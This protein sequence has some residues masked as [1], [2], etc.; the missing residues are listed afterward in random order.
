MDARKKKSASMKNGTMAAVLMVMAALSFAFMQVVVKL[1]AL[2][3][4]TMQQVFCR[5][6]ISMFIAALI[7][8]RRGCSFHIV[9][10]AR[11]PL[12]WRSACGFI[13]VVMLFYA[14]RNA[15]QADVSLMSHTS[16]V[17]VALFARLILKEK[18]PK[19]QIPIIVLCLMGTFIVVQASFESNYKYMIL[20]LLTAVASGVAYTMI[21]YCR[22]K[23]D[24]YMIIFHFS[25]FSTLAAGILMIPSFV[26]PT[27]KE[28][29]M[30]ALIGIFGAGGQIG[31]TFAY[32]KAS[33]S[34]V[35]IY[36]Y[37]GIIHSALLGYLILGEELT[38]STVMGMVFIIG[39]ALWSYIWNRREEEKLLNKDS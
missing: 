31:V 2:R 34:E 4:G 26:M 14:T 6:L 29:G 36:D 8:K 37:S 1:S 18:I 10:E 22:N 38:M 33:A 15:K 16:A 27:L 39:G 9:K 24:P 13:G 19:V 20:A 28:L 32:Q 11:A 17:W 25:A 30:L 7:I 23:V 3:V 12:M 35:S 5:N 21:A